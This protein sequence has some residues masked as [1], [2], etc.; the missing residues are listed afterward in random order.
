MPLPILPSTTLEISRTLP[1]TVPRRLAVGIVDTGADT[2]LILIAG[3]DGVLIV[4]DDGARDLDHAAVIAQRPATAIRPAD[5]RAGIGV[6]FP[7]K[8]LSVIVNRPLLS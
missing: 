8:K 2:G 7:C 1:D 5:I 3:A 6:L 4:A